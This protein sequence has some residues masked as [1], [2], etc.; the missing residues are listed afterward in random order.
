MG[1]QA[2]GLAEYAL[3]IFVVILTAPIPR[4]KMPPGQRHHYIERS[5]LA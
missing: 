4:G 3:V 1:P 2:W 5:L